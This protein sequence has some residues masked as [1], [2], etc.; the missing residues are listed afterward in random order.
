[1]TFAEVEPLDTDT[2]PRAADIADRP[3]HKNLLAVLGLA[4]GLIGLI[5]GAFAVHDL[6]FEHP[7]PVEINV[8]ILVDSSNEATERFDGTTKGQ[9]TVLALE[10]ALQVVASSDNLGL[11]SFGG[12]CNASAT[13]VLVPMRTDNKESVRS[14]AT[15]LTFDG[16][17]TL[18]RGIV[19]ATGD[20][21]DV[22]R[23]AGRKKRLVVV[24]GGGDACGESASQFAISGQEIAERL[25]T[26]GVRT[27]I[28]LIGV[29]I[30]AG[31]RHE[32]ESVAAAAGAIIRYAESRTDLNALMVQATQGQLLADG[33]AGTSIGAASTAYG[34]SGQLLAA[35]KVPPAAPQDFELVTQADVEANR[36]GSFPQAPVGR[37]S[38]RD[39]H[40]ANRSEVPRQRKPDGDTVR[41]S[42]AEVPRSLGLEKRNPQLPYIRIV[43]P[44]SET[45]LSKIA[46]P[47]RIEVQFLAP[48]GA[49]IDPSSF[50]MLYGLLKIDLTDRLSTHAR[51]TESG[52]VIDR[53]ILPSGNHRL[54]IRI[55]ADN[56]TTAERELRFVV[57]Q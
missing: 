6:L 57:S 56:G 12:D 38:D 17:R 50:R 8:Q 34:Q 49:R 3:W 42:K 29:G 15:K 11:R 37:D 46:S 24:T 43:S 30:P 7:D 32:L 36:A 20:F 16:R 40:A 18:V 1:V 45:E 14:A 28:F 9:A 41:T 52:V 19:E 23:F 2:T 26:A 27:E 48:S 54:L 21:N 55:S 31:S 53:A 47:V 13:S 5:T 35:A 44:R 22:K 10:N 33:T 25:S 4:T 51:V 39:A